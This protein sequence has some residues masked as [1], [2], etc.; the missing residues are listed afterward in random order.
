VACR[1]ASASPAFHERVT[2]AATPHVRVVLADFEPRVFFKRFSSGILSY[3]IL[4]EIAVAHRAQPLQVAVVHIHL[5]V[6]LHAVLAHHPAQTRASREVEG[7]QDVN[8]K[9]VAK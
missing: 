5:D 9:S 2:L 8:N 3:K 7:D 4:A 6:A 1:A